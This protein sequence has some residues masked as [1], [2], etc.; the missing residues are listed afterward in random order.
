M[1]LK[2]NPQ[3]KPKSRKARYKVLRK[4]VRSSARSSQIHH[5]PAMQAAFLKRFETLED[6]DVRLRTRFKLETLLVRDQADQ[7]DHVTTH[8]AQ[9]PALE[10]DNVGS[11]GTHTEVNETP[12]APNGVK[13]LKQCGNPEGWPEGV[14]YLKECDNP[15]GLLFKDTGKFDP[16]QCYLNCFYKTCQNS[17]SAYYC[18]RTS[19]ALKGRC[20]NSMSENPSV[21]IVYLEVFAFE[22]LMTYLWVISLANTL[23]F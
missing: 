3:P 12:A 17:A 21:E 23:G 13:Y 4:P 20:S 18:T 16:C 5:L 1:K 2:N 6:L 8:A 22:P 19:C 14:K 11:D 7:A 15:E 9:V 10:S